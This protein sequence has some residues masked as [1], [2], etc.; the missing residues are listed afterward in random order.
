VS[1]GEAGPGRVC[2]VTFQSPLFPAHGTFIHG[3][4]GILTRTKR[5][6]VVILVILDA[7]SKFVF[8][9]RVRTISSQVVIVWK[10]RFSQLMAHLAPS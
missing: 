10:E 3:F 1:E 7:F 8:F 5:G 2:G 6:N 9:R 4:R